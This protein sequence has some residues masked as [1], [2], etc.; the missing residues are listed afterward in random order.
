MIKSTGRSSK[1]LRHILTL[2]LLKMLN[3]WRALAGGILRANCG[4]PAHIKDSRS[5]HCAAFGPGSCGEQ[6]SL[7]FEIVILFVLQFPIHIFLS[8][9]AVLKLRGVKRNT[10]T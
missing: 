1:L 3:R 7:F 10:I 8:L 4:T 2:C 9:E 5:G 6:L